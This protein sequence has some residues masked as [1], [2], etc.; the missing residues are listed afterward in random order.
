MITLVFVVL[1]TSLI[2]FA[3]NLTWFSYGVG[4]PLWFQQVLLGFLI[5]LSSITLVIE[6][7]SMK[8]LDGG[9]L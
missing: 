5:I 7:I 3:S 1:I 6:R 9:Y 8:Y 2:M 4:I